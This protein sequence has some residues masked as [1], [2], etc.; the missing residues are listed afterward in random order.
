MIGAL[1][2]THLLLTGENDA[3][4]N[5]RLAGYRS[6]LLT[7]AHDL[8]IRLLPAFENTATGL[9]FPRVNLL[10]GILDGTI[11]NETNVAGAGS[12]L[13]EF[14]VLSR[15]L[16]DDIFERLA[17]RANERLFESRDPQTG[18][19]GNII[20]IQTGEWRGE[21]AGLGAGWLFCRTYPF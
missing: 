17:R 5:L 3:L 14:G 15:L 16:G 10:R 4:G 21:Q 11:V 8:A 19:L 7:M 18:L 20:D 2:S 1:L 9:P 6:E 12:L 13:L